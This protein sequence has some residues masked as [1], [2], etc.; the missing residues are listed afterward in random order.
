MIVV[1]EGK[2]CRVLRAWEGKTVVCIASGPSVT[3]EQLE[4][5]R[6][7]RERDLVRVL[8][9]NDMYLVAP[10]ADACYFADA[11]WWE[12]HIGGIPR[13][14]P[15]VR[16]NPDQV[17]AAHGAFRGQWISIEHPNA[18]Q[19]QRVHLLRCLA[20]DGLSE[21]PAGICTGQNS[22]FQMLNVAALSGGRRIPLLGYDMKN[23]GSRTHSH[24]GHRKRG[25]FMSDKLLGEFAQM[26]STM[27]GALERR[28]IEVLNCTPGSTI[29]AFRNASLEEALGACAPTS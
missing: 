19:D 2:T 26:F 15:W 4:R 6:E 29:K 18:I 5:V 22:G 9:T 10:W 8:V 28:G 12:W 7:A 1:R 21:D 25:P 17:K 27:K 23:D 20:T 14:W 13:E 3:R 11:K 24:D 16:F